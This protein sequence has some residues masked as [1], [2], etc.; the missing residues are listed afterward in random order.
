M[1]SASASPAA[2]ETEAAVQTARRADVA[3]GQRL[4]CPPGGR[5]PGGVAGVV[6]PADGQLP[7]EQRG[8]GQHRADAVRRGLR[9]E[10]GR[11][12]RDGERRTWMAG[13]NECPHALQGMTAP[14]VEYNRVWIIGPPAHPAA[15]TDIPA[16]IGR[17]LEL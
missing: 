5:V 4:V 3:A 15:T 13:D 9:R 11:Q 14:V 8:R 10:Q 16:D 7:G 6:G 2:A 12:G 17:T 1:A